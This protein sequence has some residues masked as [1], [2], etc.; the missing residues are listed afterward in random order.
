MQ[1][2]TVSG[3]LLAIFQ[4]NAPVVLGIRKEIFLKLVLN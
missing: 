4:N 3:V 2:F 1:G